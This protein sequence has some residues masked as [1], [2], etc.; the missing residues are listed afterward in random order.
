[1]LYNSEPA[2]LESQSFPGFV[3]S[4]SRPSVIVKN[5]RQKYYS[6]SELQQSLLNSATQTFNYVTLKDEM[7]LKDTLSL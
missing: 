2:A 5:R 3:G 1:M 4:V 6:M 7:R